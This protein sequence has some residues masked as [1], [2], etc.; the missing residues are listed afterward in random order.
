MIYYRGPTWHGG[1][2]WFLQGDN[3]FQTLRE[4]PGQ[5]CLEVSRSKPRARGPVTS[6][7]RFTLQS[8]KLKITTCTGISR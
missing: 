4:K 1:Q 7:T 6:V 8:K 5:T 2:G 3:P